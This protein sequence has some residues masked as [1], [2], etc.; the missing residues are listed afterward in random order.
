MQSLDHWFG[1]NG[2]A[3]NVRR[4]RPP[5]LAQGRKKHGLCV[6]TPAR[7]IHSWQCVSFDPP[8]FACTRSIKLVYN[9]M[10]YP[11]SLLYYLCILK[12]L[13]SFLWAPNSCRILE[14]GSDTWILRLPPSVPAGC[15]FP[16]F[17]DCS[18][19]S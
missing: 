6:S 3:D 14:K 11:I 4:G 8:V 5:L 1:Q 19:S 9:P 17:T 18:D 16:L 15:S 2:N 10:S 12:Y 7:P 13:F